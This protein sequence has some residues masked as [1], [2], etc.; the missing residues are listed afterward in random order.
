[1]GSSI[2]PLFSGRFTRSVWL[3]RGARMA[4]HRIL[5]SLRIGLL[6]LFAGC[7]PAA[8]SSPPAPATA[9]ENPP[10]ESR[11]SPVF[12]DVNG[13]QLRPAAAPPPQ[14]IALVFILADCPLANSYP[15]ELNRLHQSF[16][17]RGIRLILVHADSTISAA[18]AAGHTRQYQIEP[19]VILDPDH[20]WVKTAQ[21]T[22]SPEAVVF[23]PAGQIVY[24]G[25]IDDQYVA[26][27]KR[28]AAVTSHDLKDAFEAILADKSPA[29]TQ[30]EPI[31]C[32]IPPLPRGQ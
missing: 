13:N 6:A 17:S 12:I 27:G 16:A 18:A 29:H 28:R 8:S 32:L 10:G 23:S 4:R 31:G 1:M 26:L 19:P 5:E 24:R 30:T 9:Q 20:R 25:R 2:S 21:A 7:S 11:F 14:A 22:A 15:P 3:R